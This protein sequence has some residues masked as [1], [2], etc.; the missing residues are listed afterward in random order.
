MCY[1]LQ[2]NKIL[3]NTILINLFCLKY[4]QLVVFRF[5]VLSL[6]DVCY[7]SAN[8]KSFSS[9]NSCVSWHFKIHRN[10]N[11]FDSCNL[12]NSVRSNL[13]S[14]T[15][16]CVSLAFDDGSIP[17]VLFTTFPPFILKRILANSY[18]KHESCLAPAGSK[19][20]VNN[21]NI[22]GAESSISSSFISFAV[23]TGRES[24]GIRSRTATRALLVNGSVNESPNR[25]N[26]SLNL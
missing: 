17:S 15:K 19:N 6:V 14:L 24:T 5:L 20:A 7:S 4:F 13:F 3:P 1:N 12:I 22:F 23:Y 8:K 25:S 16:T 10:E 9:A 21:L 26:S 2:R 11:I 18:S